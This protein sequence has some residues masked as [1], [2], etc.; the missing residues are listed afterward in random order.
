MRSLVVLL[1][2]LS[3]PFLALADEKTKVATGPLSFKMKSID[4][5]ELNLAD[6]KGKVVMFVNVASECGLTPQYTGLGKLH[7]KYADKGL[8][9]IGVPANEFGS[10]E[11]GTDKEIAAFCKDKYDVKFVMLSKVVVKGKDICPLYQHLTSKETNPKFSGDIK[12]N[13]AKFVVG[14]DGEVVARFE[15]GVKPEDKKIVEVIEKELD[16]KAK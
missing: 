1:F 10:Q 15:P 13:F 6:Y 2:A 9:I 16:K 3:M 11:P 7:D 14:R 8:V 12:W 4:G 5:K